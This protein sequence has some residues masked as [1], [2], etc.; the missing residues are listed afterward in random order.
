MLCFFHIFKE[1]WNNDLFNFDYYRYMDRYSYQY[2]HKTVS[3]A[4]RGNQQIIS[5]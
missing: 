2:S 3:L 1:Y 5:V 4:S